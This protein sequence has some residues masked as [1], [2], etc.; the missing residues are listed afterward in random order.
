MLHVAEF[1]TA[2]AI[3]NATINYLWELHLYG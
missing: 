2:V 1:A 3:W